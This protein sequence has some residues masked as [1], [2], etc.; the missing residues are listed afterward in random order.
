[1]IRGGIG[2]D[3]D[4]VAAGGG[5]P[6]F[7]LGA[8]RKQAAI[9]TELSL[10]LA[11]VFCGTNYAAT[12][13]AAEFIPPLPI[14]AFRFTVGGILMFSLL[15]VLE[16]GDRLTPKDLLPVAGLGCLGVA[17]GQT[18]FTFGV[19]MTTAANTGLIFA[20]A[21]ARGLAR[22]LSSLARSSGSRSL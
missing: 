7:D 16:P 8:D 21:F 6:A 10:M 18:A 13:Y 2:R 20:V 4:A 12:K 9:L 1:L 17:I 19:S 14:V 5:P 22:A 3:P 11:A 15:R